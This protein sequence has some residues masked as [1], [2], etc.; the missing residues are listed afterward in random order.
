MDT[1]LNSALLVL[2]LLQGKHMFA[3]YFLQTPR[4]LAGRSTYVHLGRTEHAALHAILSFLVL[5]ICGATLLFSVIICVVEWVAHY[6]IDWVKGCYSQRKKHG[7]TDAAYWRAF[8]LDQLMHQ[9]TYVAMIWAF[10]RYGI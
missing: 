6:H 9:L 10:V 5:K 2:I 7:P 3:D 8:G 4:M 1:A